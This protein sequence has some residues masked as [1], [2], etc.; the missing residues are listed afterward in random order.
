M[1]T[2]YGRQKQW[3]EMLPTQWWY[4]KPLYHSP[5]PLPSPAPEAQ[6][7][8]EAK[9]P[10]LSSFRLDDKVNVYTDELKRISQKIELRAYP[11]TIIGRTADYYILGWKEDDHLPD[12]ALLRN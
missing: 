9:M 4:T 3:T 8:L 2:F 5:L 10:T 6:S 1:A 7:R 12:D 11:A